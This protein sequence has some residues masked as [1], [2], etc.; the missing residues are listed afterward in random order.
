MEEELEKMNQEHNEFKEKLEDIL[1]KL[2]QR[3]K[4]L[5]E[6]KGKRKSMGLIT[7]SVEDDINKIV[8]MEHKVLRDIKELDED[9][10][11]LKQDFLSLH[12]NNTKKQKD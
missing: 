10:E 11:K 8:E 12:A 3:R 9:F 5:E 6:D 4:E 1:S 2:V 7:Y